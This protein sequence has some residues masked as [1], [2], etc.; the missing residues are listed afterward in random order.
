MSVKGRVRE[1]F[2]VTSSTAELP[3]FVVILAATPVLR[4]LVVTSDLVIAFITV[5]VLF[6]IVFFIR[7]FLRLLL[8]LHRRTAHF[9]VVH[10]HLYY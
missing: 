3:P 8:L 6:G 10:L 9:D 4:L 7:V 5:K 2:L 1:V